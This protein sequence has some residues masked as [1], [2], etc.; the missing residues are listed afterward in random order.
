MNVGKRQ[1][2]LFSKALKAIYKMDLFVLSHLRDVVEN[3]IED[4]EANG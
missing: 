3:M 2:T 1:L 4:R